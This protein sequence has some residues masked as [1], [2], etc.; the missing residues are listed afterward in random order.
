MSY[1]Y[2]PLC[3][4]LVLSAWGVP[5]LG[6]TPS[7][8]LPPAHQLALVLQA[9]GRPRSAAVEWRRL[10]MDEAERSRKAGYY[11]AAAYQYLEA[12]DVPVAEKLLDQAEAAWLPIED[13]ALMLRAQVAGAQQDRSTAAFYWGSIL[14]G[15]P[16]PGPARMARRQLASLAL[17]AGDSRQARELLEWSPADESRALEAILSFEQ[18]RDKKPVVGGLLGMIPGMG[19][20]YAG[21]YANAFRSFLLNGI[22]IYGMVD[23]ARND[24]W[25][26]FAVITFFELTWYSGSIYGGID[27]SHRYNQRRR[28]TLH[29]E[30]KG[31]ALFEPD[32]LAIPQVTLQFTF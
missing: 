9:G 2:V 3:S 5:C 7:A 22:F 31:Q 8:T 11:W 4:L 24:H 15:Q 6:S 23:T 14:R 16:E 28:D 32:W 25:G 17:H 29:D 26:A 27:A 30:V 12:G 10:A 19:Y 13:V 20:A 1:S 21:E 18:G